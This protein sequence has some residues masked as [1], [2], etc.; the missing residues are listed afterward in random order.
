[1]SPEYNVQKLPEWMGRVLP[2]MGL[3]LAEAERKYNDLHYET[4]HLVHLLEKL[5]AM[6]ML[7]LE[8]QEAP[9]EEGQELL[10]RGVRFNILY[11]QNKRLVLQLPKGKRFRK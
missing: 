11:V 7:Q 8:L 3:T 6:N 1:M 5:Y 9:F 10:V 2:A 4:V